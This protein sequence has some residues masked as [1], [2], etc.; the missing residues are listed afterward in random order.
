M[1]FSQKCTERRVYYYYFF[2]MIKTLW[3]EKSHL[4]QTNGISVVSS[5]AVQIKT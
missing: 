1:G 4:I 5:N 2:L 3:S